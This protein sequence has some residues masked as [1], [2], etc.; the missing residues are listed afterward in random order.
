MDPHIHVAS[1][2]NPRIHA[3][4]SYSN[5]PIHAAPSYSN[6]RILLASRPHWAE[7]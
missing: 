7:P 2:S 4:P 1:D 5:P 3:A 6:P